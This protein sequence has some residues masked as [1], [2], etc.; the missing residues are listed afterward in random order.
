[1]LTTIDHAGRLVIPKPLRERLKL[2]AGTRVD[3]IEVDGAIEIRPAPHPVTL[4]RSR[5]KPRLH[6]S[7]HV[8]PLTG[9]EVRD[10]IDETRR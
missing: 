6:A 10:L 5:G 8:P 7:G 1:M 2:S 9:D 4:D 3:I